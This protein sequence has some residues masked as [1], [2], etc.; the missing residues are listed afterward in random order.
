[1]PDT[2]LIP[3]NMDIIFIVSFIFSLCLKSTKIPKPALDNNPATAAP[4]LIDPFI[5][6]IAS[7]IDVAQFGISPNIEVNT[8]AKN[9]HLAKIE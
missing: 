1:M 2:I 5:K 7:A 4:K 6:S 9:L 8:G 3:N